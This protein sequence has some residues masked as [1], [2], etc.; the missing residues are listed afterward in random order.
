MLSVKM[1]GSMIET[2]RLKLTPVALE[3]IEIY[4]KLLTCEVTTRYLPD[5][6]PFSLEYIEN[7]VPE[8]VGRWEKGFG[9]FII[10]LKDDPIVKIGYAGVE[11]IPNTKFSDIRYGLLPEFQGKGYAF[12]AS[13]AVLNFTLETGIV[14]EVYGVA[15][16]KNRASISLLKNWV[17]LSPVI[18]F[19]T[20]MNWL[21]CLLKHAYNKAFKSD[22]ATR[23]SFASLTVWHA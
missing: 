22:S 11:Q 19:T 6:K 9:T 14:S 8:K 2:E 5:G 4:T 10:S 1:D 17:C 3:D 13:K 7:Y 16:I 21:R 15:V 18:N 20:V 23:A 12:E